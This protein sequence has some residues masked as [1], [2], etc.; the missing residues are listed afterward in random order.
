[1]TM[2]H[3]L[4][5]ERDRRFV[6]NEMLAAESLCEKPV[7]ADFSRDMFDMVLTEAQKIAVQKIFPTLVQSDRERCR[8]ENGQ[9][10]VPECFQSVYKLF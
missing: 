6:L 1:M 4:V 9:V 3:L 5:D 7:Y 10:Y 8:L 2:A